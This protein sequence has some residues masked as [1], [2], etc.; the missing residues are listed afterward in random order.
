MSTETVMSWEMDAISPAP[1]AAADRARRGA[2]PRR[3]VLVRA[4]AGAPPG[5]LPLPAAAGAQAA[6][7]PAGLRCAHRQPPEYYDFDLFAGAKAT[8][9]GRPPPGRS[10]LHRVRHRDHRPGPVGRRRDH[11]DR[12]HA[13]RQRQAA[14][15]ESLSSSWS[16]RSA[17]PAAG[18]PDPRHHAGDGGRPAHHRQV[19][20]AFH[21][22][23]QDTVLVAHN[24]AFDMR[25]LQLKEEA[26]GLRFDQP[27]LDTLLLSAVVHPQQESTGW[28]RLPSAS[29]VVDGAATPRWATRWSPP[30]CS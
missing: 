12:R 17:D 25:F 4:R 15:S 8:R 3:R 19:L 28:R 27:V 20:P 24:A 23:A 18:D 13:H 29:G 6:A 7:E 1:T 10:G 9:T 14:A 26:T 30:R 5:L 11:P 2:A 16:T 21:A 22:F